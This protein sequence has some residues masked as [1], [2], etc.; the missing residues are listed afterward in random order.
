VSA[1]VENH[2]D[3]QSGRPWRDGRQKITLDIDRGTEHNSSMTHPAP[4]FSPADR[5]AIRRRL[6]VDRPLHWELA[7]ALFAAL[8]GAWDELEQARARSATAAPR[9]AKDA[10]D[11]T[12]PPSEN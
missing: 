2:Q 5:E 7:R 9:T 8:E 1:A 12:P 10:A 6:M 3:L 4:R 11:E